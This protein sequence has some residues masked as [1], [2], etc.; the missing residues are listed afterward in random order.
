MRNLTL[1]HAIVNDPNS[2]EKKAS[3]KEEKK[4]LIIDIIRKQRKCMHDYR[5]R[6]TLFMLTSVL[7]ELLTTP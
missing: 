5:R 3:K 1:K 4:N 7:E 6:G 2:E